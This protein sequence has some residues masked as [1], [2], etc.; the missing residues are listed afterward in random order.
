MFA[1]V[2]GTNKGMLGNEGEMTK[3]WCY[4]VG[5]QED[6]EGKLGAQKCA[7]SPRFHV[8]YVHWM[9]RMKE[10]AENK[11]MGDMKWLYEE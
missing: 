10:G 3:T 4:S 7:L 8:S 9:T 2:P 5:N 6:G 11:H 1:R